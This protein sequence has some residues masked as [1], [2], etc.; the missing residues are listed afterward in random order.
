M[1]LRTKYNAGLDREIERMK[2]VKIAGW[3]PFS[4]DDLFEIDKRQR[5]LRVAARGNVLSK[6]FSWLAPRL[7]RAL[8][9]AMV[10]APIKLTGAEQR[11]KAAERK[12]HRDEEGFRLRQLIGRPKGWAP[13][14]VVVPG[15]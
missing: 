8:L 4:A 15:S 12:A 3:S 9:A 6:R 5:A 11:R 14:R 7:A 1:K 10:P 2:N 13:F